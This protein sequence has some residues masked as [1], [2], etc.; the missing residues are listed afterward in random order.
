MLPSKGDE[1]YIDLMPSFPRND[2][3]ADFSVER[4]RYPTI[5]TYSRDIL[6]GGDM[7]EEF[8]LVEGSTISFMV[9]RDFYDKFMGLALCVVFSVDNGEKEILFDIVPH[10]NGQRRN[11]LSG[12][13]G[14]FDSDHMWIQYLKPNV[15]WGMLEGAVDFLEFDEDRLRF[16]LTLSILGGT[17]KKFGYVLR[18]KQIDD[19]LKVVL[20]DNQLVDPASIYEMKFEEFFY[21]FLPRQ[22]KG[23][24]CQREESKRL[25]E[26]SECQEE[27]AREKLKQQMEEMNAS[28]SSDNETD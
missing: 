21:K 1:A 28:D 16:S 7:P 24:E 15:L 8:V 6:P 23:L 4:Y 12:S 2:I 19:D 17:M 3:M 26:E 27:C 14:S 22:K 18:C 11:R 9:S 13:L 5:S 25:M 10:V 20:E